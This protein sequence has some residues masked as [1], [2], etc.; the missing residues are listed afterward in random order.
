MDL[1]RQGRPGPIAMS[2]KG[3]D[4]L[5]TNIGMKLSIAPGLFPSLIE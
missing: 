4:Y 5:D 2:V 3:I 1:Q